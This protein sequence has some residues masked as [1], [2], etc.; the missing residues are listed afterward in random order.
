MTKCKFWKNKI[1]SK[2]VRFMNLKLIISLSDRIRINRV[3][4]LNRYYMEEACEFRS[5]L[6]KQF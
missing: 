3:T 6:S 4:V 1:R 5:K 2:V